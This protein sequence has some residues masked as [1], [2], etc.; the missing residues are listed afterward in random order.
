VEAVLTEHPDVRQCKVVGLPDERWG[1]VACAAVVA[2]RQV[3]LAEVRAWMRGRI[4]DDKRPRCLAQLAEL[5]T[6]HTDKMSRRGLREV[7]L[8]GHPLQTAG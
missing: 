8:A 3:S 2:D 5:P 1:Q 6:T 7:L 4:A